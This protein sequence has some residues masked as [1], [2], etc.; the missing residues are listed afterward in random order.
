EFQWDPRHYERALEIKVLID[1]LWEE[2]YQNDNGKKREIIRQIE[3]QVESMWRDYKAY[4]DSKGGFAGLT[5][6]EKAYLGVEEQN[7]KEAEKSLTPA[8]KVAEKDKQANALRRKALQSMGP[9]L[10]DVYAVYWIFNSGTTFLWQDIKDETIP[11]DLEKFAA[12]VDGIGSAKSFVKSDFRTMIYSAIAKEYNIDVE[13]V[14]FLI[15]P[16]DEDQAKDDGGD[17]EKGKKPE[18]LE[19]EFSEDRIRNLT[20][21]QKKMLKRLPK[22][23]QKSKDHDALV[24]L[25]DHLLTLPKDEQDALIKEMHEKEKQRAESDKKT[26]DDDKDKDQD[27]KPRDPKIDVDELKQEQKVKKDAEE[28]LKDKVKDD[29]QLE[30][31]KSERAEFLKNLS[32]QERQAF[33]EFL[34]SVKSDSQHADKKSAKE[35]YDAYKQLSETDK[36]ALKVKKL[37]NEQEDGAENIDPKAVRAMV[38]QQQDEAK[39]AQATVSDMNEDMAFIAGLVSDPDAKK[40]L[41]PFDPE[42][43]RIM[44]EMMMLYGIMDG[45]GRMSPE[46]R[47]AAEGLKSQIG[48][49]R[50]KLLD[51]IKWIAIELGVHAGLGAIPVVGWLKTAASAARLIRLG[52]RLN[53]L[54]KKLNALKRGYDT[55]NRVRTAIGQA[56]SIVNN[57]PGFVKKFEQARKNWEVL[58]AQLDNLDADENIEERLE[59]AFDQ[60]ME[61]MEQRLED[62]EP[63]LEKLYL[64]EEVRDDTEALLKVLFSI[65]KGIDSFGDMLGSYEKFGDTS[66]PRELELLYYK[67]AQTGILLYPLVGFVIGEL[68][69]ALREWLEEE[70]G[71]DDFLK[72]RDTWKSKGG[73]GK[74]ATRSKFGSLWPRKLEYKDHRKGHTPQ[75]EAPLK[76]GAEYLDKEIPKTDVP[77][78]YRIKTFLRLKLRQVIKHLNKLNI[79]VEG[80]RKPRRKQTPE[81]WGPV[82]LPPF[83]YKLSRSGKYHNIILKINPEYER[84]VEVLDYPAFKDK[85]ITLP[86]FQTDEGKALKK[87]LDSNGYELTDLPKI[88]WHIRRSKRNAVTKE[89]LRIK[90]GH[91]V[92][93]L[94]SKDSAALDRFVSADIPIGDN[95]QLPDGFH[96]QAL[97]LS[98]TR[99]DSERYTVKKHPNTSPAYQ[100]HLNQAAKL[101]K[102]PASGKQ[103]VVLDNTAPADPVPDSQG[104]PYKVTNQ[105]V[106]YT[107]NRPRGS[108][109]KVPDMK[110]R[111]DKGHLIAHRFNGSNNL[112]NLVAMNRK[113]NQKG[114]WYKQEAALANAFK[115]AWQAA[116]VAGQ[117][118]AAFLSITVNYLSTNKTRRPNSFDMSWEVKKDGKQYESDSISNQENK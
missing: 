76:K 38:K 37:L 35:I 74:S 67:G 39:Q 17:G 12:A 73:P 14:W 44:P 89:P 30:A 94:E 48:Q 32:E 20:K 87:W 27:K 61:Q 80:R 95:V 65:P 82:P 85:G 22:S 56:R 41:V 8:N 24:N 5:D 92:Q 118:V 93:G 58:Q 57:V 111:D 86:D 7:I 68:S 90:D 62:L 49:I 50:G 100:L 21:K 97:G 81:P 4:V 25:L 83:K 46:L 84:K 54:R 6:E 47:E 102:G 29:A 13:D 26:G 117:K 104:R 101:A 45:A 53:D 72:K 66:D 16:Q 105:Q 31:E 88:G 36:E 52:I 108:L 34:E 40:A 64:P 10:K 112:A 107:V 116:A 51:E 91:I 33:L 106:G 109:P 103:A 75:F 70:K 19:G 77:W 63:F 43:F 59:L 113:L 15:E 2:E 69:E 60:L 28:I 11:L 96:L 3:A 18:N 98:G 42:D 9:L 71:L 110:K 79:K 23:V 115:R 114:A 78:R 55:F 99:K 1:Q